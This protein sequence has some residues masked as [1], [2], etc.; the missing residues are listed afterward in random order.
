MTQSPSRVSEAQLQELGLEVEPEEK[1]KME[2]TIQA[3][4]TVCPMVFLAKLC[5]F[6]R[7]RGWF[8]LL[9]AYLFA[10]CPCTMPLRPTSFLRRPAL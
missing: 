8:D 10:G 2:L 5:G 6:R 1:N 9:P 7:R 4:L 3:F